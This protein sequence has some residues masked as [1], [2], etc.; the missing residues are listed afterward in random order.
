MIAPVRAWLAAAAVL[1]VLFSTALVPDA[2][3]PRAEAAA[4]CVRDTNIG[5]CVVPQ[6]FQIAF[7]KESSFIDTYDWHTQSFTDLG[8]TTIT[9]AD[10]T[11]RQVNHYRFK[12]LVVDKDILIDQN[13]GADYRVQITAPGPIELGG[14]NNAGQAMWT[15]VWGTNLE[16]Q[17]GTCIITWTW[18]PDNIGLNIS[19]CW[20]RMNAYAITAYNPQPQPGQRDNPINLP[21]STLQLLNGGA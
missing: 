17:W 14:T 4:G 19:G 18:V 9:V 12:Q 11:T 20:L 5:F 1:L 2:S 7:G 6:A 13:R 16:F 15:D 21:K 10:G 3:V 8:T